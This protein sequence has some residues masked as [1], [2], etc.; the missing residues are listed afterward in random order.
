VCILILITYTNWLHVPVHGNFGWKSQLWGPNTKNA[1]KHHVFNN[2]F[3]QYP[4]DG[5]LSLFQHR[6]THNSRAYHTN[7]MA[8]Q[9]LHIRNVHTYGVE[10]MTVREHAMFCSVLTQV[11]WALS[12]QFRTL[13]VLWHIL[14]KY[15]TNWIVKTWRYYNTFESTLINSLRTGFWKF[16]QC[17]LPRLNNEQ[18]PVSAPQELSNEWSCHVI[19]GGNLCVLPLVT[20]VAI[21]P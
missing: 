13:G 19:F 14:P 1:I 20:E 4:T 3:F 17:I 10:G 9:Q 5:K 15:L 11:S 8:I 7:V 2:L 21:G 12:H 18:L 6:M 16:R